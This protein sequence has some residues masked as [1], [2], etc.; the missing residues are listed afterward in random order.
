MACGSIY[1]PPIKKL[2]V[3]FVTNHEVVLVHFKGST[4]GYEAADREKYNFD[5]SGY[6]VKR[7]RWEDVK[8][9]D[10]IE[11]P[12]GK[13]VPADCVILDT[14]QRYGT[15]YVIVDHPYIEDDTTTLCDCPYIVR[16][17]T[18][19]VLHRWAM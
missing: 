7:K 12:P 14:A 11:M 18:M 2:P 1:S 16:T 4:D 17:T 10:I 19:V 6:S 9:G 8:V 15:G 5:W 3:V 13:P